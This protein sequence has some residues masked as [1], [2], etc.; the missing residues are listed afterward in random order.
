MRNT[1]IFIF[2]LTL[3]PAVY[4][5]AYSQKKVGGV[6]VPQTLPQS[7]NLTLNGAG[8]REKYF[9]DLYVGALYLKSKSTDASQI[10]SSNDPIGIRLHIISDKIT[11]KKMEE[12]V[13]EGF[14]KST[15]GNTTPYKDKIDKLI[16]AFKEDVKV[17]D[18]YD[19]IYTPEGGTKVYKNNALKIHIQ[20]QDFKKVLFGIWLGSSPV[21]S[22]LKSDMMGK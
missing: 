16:S 2:L 22:D 4:N 1:W 19:I 9:F 12:S 14:T 6:T 10:L 8:I 5:A 20:G 17:G 7:G 13:R 18:I 3:F 21:D 11:S 15:G